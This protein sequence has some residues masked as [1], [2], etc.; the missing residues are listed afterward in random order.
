MGKQAVAPVGMP[1]FA[2]KA[3][4]LWFWDRSSTGHPPPIFDLQTTLPIFASEQH[5]WWICDV[6]NCWSSVLSIP[7][8]LLSN[9]RLVDFWIFPLETP[10]TLLFSFTIFV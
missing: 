8:W 3:I 7:Y 2:F 1:T 4:L 5:I 9:T 10:S 6:S